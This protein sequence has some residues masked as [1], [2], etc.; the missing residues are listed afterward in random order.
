MQQW[1]VIS[2]Y[3]ILIESHDATRSI[4]SNAGNARVKACLKKVG[5][6]TFYMIKYLPL[7]V[8]PKLVQ[9]FQRLA[10]TKKK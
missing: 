10:G 8:P 2:R 3:L 9:A 7:K 5:L 6:V 1:T 4:T